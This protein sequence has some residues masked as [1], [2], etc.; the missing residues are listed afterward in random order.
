[1]KNTQLVILLLAILGLTSC[2]RTTLMQ[3]LQPAEMK[4]PDHLTVVAT[5]DR[6]KPSDG[7]LR[8]VEGLF[9]GEQIGQDQRGRLNALE[10]LNDALSNTPRFQLKM[11][12]VVM[13]GSKTGERISEPLSWGEIDRIC[14]DYDADC[15]LAIESYDSDLANFTEGFEET[16]KDDDGN[17]QTRRRWRAFSD[18]GVKVGW[19]LYDP[20]KRVIV[21]E[22]MTRASERYSAEGDT[23]RKARG[24]LPNMAANVFQISWL[25][26]QR[27]GMRIAPVW[28]TVAREFYTNG[29]RE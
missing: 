8:V 18:I 28:V 10:G 7:F 26:G 9:T 2:T 19:R 29:K 20:Q 16:Y 15:V 14:K 12:N 4:M 11:T 21:D 3:V 23:E 22:F 25:A 6:S 1:M 5:I 17:K 13:E 27:Y 24:G